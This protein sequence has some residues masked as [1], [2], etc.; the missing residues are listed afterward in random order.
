MSLTR[1]TSTTYQSFVQGSFL[2]SISVQYNLSPMVGVQSIDLTIVRVAALHEPKW[3]SMF[4]EPSTTA[5]IVSLTNSKKAGTLG[6]ESKC[7]DIE[8][9]G[10]VCA[11]MPNSKCLGQQNGIRLIANTRL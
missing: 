6:L 1:I 8:V 10:H 3:H 5:A 4:E 2:I 9:K 7:V 11:Y